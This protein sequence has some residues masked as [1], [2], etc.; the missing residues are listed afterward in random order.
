MVVTIPLRECCTA[1]KVAANHS[2]EPPPRHAAF[3]VATV[4]AATAAMRTAHSFFGPI[5]RPAR[6]PPHSSR[7]GAQQAGCDNT[8][9]LAGA[10]RG[11]MQPQ[12][13]CEHT[14]ARRGG[15]AVDRPSA[16]SPRCEDP[17][18]SA[19]LLHALAP[20][21]E[22]PPC[23]TGAPVLHVQLRALPITPRKKVTLYI[24]YRCQRSFPLATR[25][26]KACQALTHADSATSRYC[27]QYAPKIAL[28]YTSTLGAYRVQYGKATVPA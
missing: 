11:G 27:T 3:T 21:W 22:C 14:S 9:A 5:Q 23:P 24:F 1:T 10:R 2:H 26:Y 18:L 16:A 28:S 15:I 12:R 20:V 6:F 8:R 25:V 17:S 13:G 19:I 4:G 7:V